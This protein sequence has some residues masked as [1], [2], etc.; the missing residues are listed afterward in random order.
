MIFC[1]EP[2]VAHRT[3]LKRRTEK[4]AKLM[5]QDVRNALYGRFIKEV[6]QTAFRLHSTKAIGSVA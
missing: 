3:Q 2:S 5:I 6:D 1:I 4:L